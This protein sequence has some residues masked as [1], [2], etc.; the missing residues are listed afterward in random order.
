MQMIHATTLRS[1]T[2]ST[3]QRI[4]AAASMLGT[5]LA[6]FTCSIVCNSNLSDLL[7]LSSALVACLCCRSDSHIACIWARMLADTQAATVLTCLWTQALL[8]GVDELPVSVCA[9]GP[10]GSGASGH[11]VEASSL[12]WQIGLGDIAG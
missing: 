8:A 9:G 4:V 11:A 12:L 3:L 7:K 1:H 10:T 2:Q 5:L 6:S